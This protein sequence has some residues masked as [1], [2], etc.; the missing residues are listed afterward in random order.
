ME[1]NQ[2]SGHV[3]QLLQ[4]FFRAGENVPTLLRLHAL[5]G[6]I[7]RP[8]PLVRRKRLAISVEEMPVER[9]EGTG[10]LAGPLPH[11]IAASAAIVRHAVDVVAAGGIGL[12]AEQAAIGELAHADDIRQFHPFKGVR[13]D[14]QIPFMD[15]D[16]P[17][18]DQHGEVAGDHQPL[19]VMGI[20]LVPRLRDH[21][22]EAGHI[23]LNR[24]VE[25]GKRARGAERI[26]RAIAGHGE[27]VDAAHIFPPAD[28][29]PDEA[30]RRVKRGVAFKTG[31]LRPPAD[32][33]RVEQPDIDVEGEE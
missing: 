3:V 29:L 31:P 13:I 33:H 4:K 23:S 25:I 6:G 2:C 20:G 30:L 16:R 17:H 7:D 27:P 21:G 14:L 8:Q 10:A 28:D 26:H 11:V 12:G 24:P 15:F 19:D 32:D 9:V 5:P 22:L 1:T 18:A